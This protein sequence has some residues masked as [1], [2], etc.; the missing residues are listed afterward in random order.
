METFVSSQ[1]RRG[2]IDNCFSSLV[3]INGYR[4]LLAVQVVPIKGSS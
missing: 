2:H 1:V 4:R 3:S